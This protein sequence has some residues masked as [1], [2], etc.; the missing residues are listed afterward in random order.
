M[1]RKKRG[2]TKE[3]ADRMAKALKLREAGLT[4]DQIAKQLGKSTSQIDRD[5]RD[6]LRLTIQEP[7]DSLRIVEARRL[8][9]LQRALWARAMRGETAAIDRILR[10]QERRARLLNLDTQGGTS[11]IRETESMLEQLLN[12]DTQ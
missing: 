5:L 6:A 10:I 3:R 9:A 12:Q 4:L 8:D 11:D 7:A 1:P 2:P